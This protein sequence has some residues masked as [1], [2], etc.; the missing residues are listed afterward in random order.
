LK[1]TCYQNY[2]YRKWIWKIRDLHHP[3]T[4]PLM[5]DGMLNFSL[6]MDIVNLKVRSLLWK[7][8]FFISDSSYSVPQSGGI[9]IRLHYWD[10][11]SWNAMRESAVINILMTFYHN[12]NKFYIRKFVINSKYDRIAVSI[13]FEFINILLNIGLEKFVLSCL[14]HF[15]IILHY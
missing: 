10:K 4:G 7:L 12:I 14:R 8:L 3:L 6:R 2:H 15:R 13:S 11:L 9:L 5:F 1:F